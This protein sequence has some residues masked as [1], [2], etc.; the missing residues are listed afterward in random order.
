MHSMIV[1]YDSIVG[2]RPDYKIA[3]KGWLDTTRCKW[4]GMQNE[5]CTYQRYYIGTNEWSNM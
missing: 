4:I 5:E 1:I 2:N 3:N